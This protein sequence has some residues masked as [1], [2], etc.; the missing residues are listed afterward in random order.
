MKVPADPLSRL[1]PLRLTA[2]GGS[3]LAAGLFGVIV[4]Y[5]AGWPALLAVSLFLIGAVVAAV[6]MVL[7][8]PAAVEV[9]RTIDP[10]IAEQRQPIRVRVGVRGSA[11]G[12]LEWREELPRSVVVTG[13][14]EGVLRSLRPDRDVEMLD[15]HLTS[16]VRGELTVGPLRVARVD[17]LGLAM[18]RRRVGVV[19]RV[20][21]L[22][23]IVPVALPFA[24][25]RNDPDARASTVVG[26]I[27]D[28]RDIVARSYRSGDPLRSVDWRAT[29]RRAQL[30]V[31]TETAAS[32]AS[33]GLVLDV[34]PEAWPESAAFEWAVDYA[35][36]LIV[37]LQDR[38]AQIRLA[39][40]AAVTTDPTAALV[41]LATVGRKAGAAA[42]AQVLDGLVTADVQVVHVLTGA[43][44][45]DELPQLPALPHGALGM[46]S[47]IERHA[48][49]TESPIGWRVV[50]RDSAA[51]IGA[52]HDG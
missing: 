33:T 24:V 27:G 18:T 49:A 1:A 14:A 48:V 20:T 7:A 25:R 30:M 15:Y 8:T 32:T 47:L 4:A 39:V 6:A 41:E 11:V 46:V 29:A 26:A 17:P 43:G 28:Q 19:D 37:A 10:R 35:A 22:P 51:E 42:I 16:R 45:A 38:Q 34:R 5:A 2:R 50:R 9:T 13:H 36:S 12:S 44:A 52:S 23:R 3:F 21:V 40:G 31:R